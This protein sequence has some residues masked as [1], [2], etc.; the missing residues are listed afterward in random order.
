MPA[1]RVQI[2]QVRNVRATAYPAKINL[3]IRPTGG[4]E[5]FQCTACA[6]LSENKDD[7]IMGFEVH[8]SWLTTAAA[9][10]TA[11]AP[12]DGHP[13]AL[14]MSSETDQ[15]E[16]ESQSTSRDRRVNFDIASTGSESSS[17]ARQR[18]PIRKKEKKKAQLAKTKAFKI[19]CSTI[20]VLGRSN[21]RFGI[22]GTSGWTDRAQIHTTPVDLHSRGG[23]R[24]LDFIGNELS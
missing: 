16:D 1:L 4:S 8:D 7:V 17:E 22:A 13:A 23:E 12:E 14:E 2:A 11:G 19:E 5:V 21:E 6:V 9:Q 3:T 20:R 18:P 24:G 10:P 15:S